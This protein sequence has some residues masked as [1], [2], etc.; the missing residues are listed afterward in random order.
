MIKNNTGAED[1]D[2]PPNDPLVI[3]KYANRRLYD[4]ANSSYIKL[5]DLS[6][7]AREGNEF[8]VQDAKTGEDL[9]RKVLIQIIL[10]NEAEEEN[11]FPLTF[12]R[13]MVGI[14]GDTMQRVV[15]GY[16]EHSMKAFQQNQ[17]ALRGQ[18]ETMMSMSPGM[19]GIE[20]LAKANQEFLKHAM[21]A[22]T[23]FAVRAADDGSDNAEL[24]SRGQAGKGELVELREQ[25]SAMQKKLDMLV[26][27]GKE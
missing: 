4:T 5:S 11:L 7:M 10:Q 18:A 23:P 16:L 3:K 13:S 1:I 17:E 21:D 27:G 2:N 6:K 20:G 12:L 9:T 22:L 15:P 19:A 8:V 26:G 14:Y 25:I 24:E